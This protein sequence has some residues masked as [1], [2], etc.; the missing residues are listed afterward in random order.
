[1]FYEA[2]IFLHLQVNMWQPDNYPY[3]DRVKIDGMTFDFNPLSDDIFLEYPKLK[4]S[5]DDK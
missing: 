3:L 4:A 2:F 5:A 1:M